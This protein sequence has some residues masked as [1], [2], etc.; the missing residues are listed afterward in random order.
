MAHSAGDSASDVHVFGCQED[1]VGDEEGAGADG[2]GSRRPQP[3]RPEVRLPI[4]VGEDLF[5]EPFVLSPTDVGQIAPI[6]PR[7]CFLV[8]VDGDVQFL[9]YPLAK[10]P[11]QHHAILHRHAAHGH[12]RHD[13]GRADAGMLSPM[14]VQVNQLSGGG[15]ALKGSLHNSLRFAHEGD[16]GAVVVGIRLHVE[17]AHVG[18]AADGIGDSVNHRLPSPLTE[19]G[20]AFDDL[21]HSVP[22]VTVHRLVFLVLGSG[23]GAEHQT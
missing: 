9:S 23:F 16:H 4:R 15:N 7:G 6:G 21:L 14:M 18:H 12:Q 5:P 20:H 22:P 1:V 17:D 2:G 10:L 3:R 19:V 8:E 13:V 11:C